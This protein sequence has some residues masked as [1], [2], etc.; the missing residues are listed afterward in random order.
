MIKLLR[1]HNSIRDFEEVEAEEL[2]LAGLVRRTKLPGGKQV[3]RIAGPIINAVVRNFLSD[4]SPENIAV[5]KH[6][7]FEREAIAVAAYRR[8][9]QLENLLRNVIASE[10]SIKFG[11]KCAKK[12]KATKTSSRYG[13]ETEELIHRILINNYGISPQENNPDALSDERNSKRKQTTIFASATD[14]QKRQRE[15][16]A[17]E[18]HQDNLMHFLTTESL[19]SV[20]ENTKNDFCGDGKPF[21]REFLLSALAEYTVSAQ[22]LRITNR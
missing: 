5:P 13:E 2:W 10:W 1:V 3:L 22:R 17:L 18:L 8:V 11:D 12:L 14:W 7:C 15:N 21:K 20:L 4:E 19:I 16:H 9:A 6:I